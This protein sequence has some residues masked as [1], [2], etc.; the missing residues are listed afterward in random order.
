MCCNWKYH[1]AECL[2]LLTLDH[3]VCGSNPAGGEIQL[4]TMVLHCTD[5]VGNPRDQLTKYMVFVTI[6]NSASG[7]MF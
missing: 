2:V 1:E 5:S 3:E 6:F 4:M 7:R